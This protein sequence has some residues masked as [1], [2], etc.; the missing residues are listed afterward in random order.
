M[1]AAS[2][3][4]AGCAVA[5]VGY[6]PASEP[7][8]AQQAVSVEVFAY[9]KAGQSAEQQRKDRYECHLWAV[10]ETGVEPSSLTVRDRVGAP[11][12]V[13][14]VYPPV[15]T[16]AA[17]AATG[18]AIGALTSSRGHRTEGA[19]VGTIIGA[20]VGS[21]AEASSERAVAQAQAAQPASTPDRA[22]A[23]DRADRYRRAISACLTGRGYQVR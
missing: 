13:V 17:T 14:P 5:P 15:A 8:P 6:V 11:P 9:P 4:L 21:I 16:T 7:A 18:A 20:I 23:V 1:L 2:A 10:R 19:I 22:S 3:L 12:E